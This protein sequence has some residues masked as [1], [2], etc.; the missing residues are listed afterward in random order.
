VVQPGLISPSRPAQ[1]P[2]FS[3]QLKLIIL[4][5]IV[6]GVETMQ[7]LMGKMMAMLIMALILLSSSWAVAGNLEP[8]GGPAPTMNTLKE[9]YDKVAIGTEIK[10]LPYTISSSGFYYITQDLTSPTGTHGITITADN[11]TLDLMGFSLVGPGGTE[12]YHGVYMNNLSN[13]EIRNGTVMNFSGHG[14]HEVSFDGKGHR[15]INVRAVSNGWCGIEL[16]GESSLVKDCTVLLNGS[17]GIVVKLGSTVTGNTVSRNGSY[18]ITANRSTITG[19]TVYLNVSTGIVAAGSGSKVTGNTANDN[20]VHGIYAGSATITGNTA[21]NNSSRG[22]ALN[23][24]SLV[25][26]NTAYNNT[27]P[28]I[29]SCTTCTFGTNHAP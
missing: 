23:G 18:G 13:V 9:I 1:S 25:D 20:G 5:Y 26:Q 19:N 2:G 27:L 29:S 11:V 10:F 6:Q 15:I 3:A 24:H 28:N 7:K 17:N 16:R 21:T 14:I 22:I 12:Y 8:P 4:F